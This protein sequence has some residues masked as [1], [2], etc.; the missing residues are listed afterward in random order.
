[1]TLTLLLLVSSDTRFQY[2][3]QPLCPLWQPVSLCQGPPTGKKQ[4]VIK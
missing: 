2:H 3:R 4:L 1:M